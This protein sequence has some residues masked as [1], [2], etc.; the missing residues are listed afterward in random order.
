MKEIMN[1]RV[2]PFKDAPARHQPRSQS[3]PHAQRIV[4]IIA[5]LNEAVTIADVVQNTKPF[6][7]HVVVVDGFSNDE[8]CAR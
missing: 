1:F 3:S 8:T 6:V 7:H 4:C 5:T 2:H